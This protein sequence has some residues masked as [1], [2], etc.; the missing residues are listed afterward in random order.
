MA[1]HNYT[2][3]PIY[4]NNQLNKNGRDA[5]NSNNKHYTPNQSA[6]ME[7]RRLLKGLC[8]KCGEKFYPGHKCT[9]HAIH[10]ILAEGDGEEYQMGCAAI[11]FNS[12]QEKEATIALCEPGDDLDSTTMKIDGKIGQFPILVLLDTGSS[13]SFIHPEIVNHLKL[14]ITKTKPLK[15]RLADGRRMTADSVC[16]TQKFQL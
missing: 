14:P 8:Y 1:L 16:N 5:T 11:E 10:A 7:E 6:L 15:V 13:H 9:R 2:Q 12:E 3:N 4:A